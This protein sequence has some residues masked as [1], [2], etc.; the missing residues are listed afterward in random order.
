MG[1]PSPQLLALGRAVR[2]A[3]RRRELTQEALGREAGVAPKHLSEIECAKRDPR[4]TT[5][6]KLGRALRLDEAEVLG[7]WGALLAAPDV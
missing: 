5:L 7:I 1:Q 6:L 2:Q 3:R 4:A